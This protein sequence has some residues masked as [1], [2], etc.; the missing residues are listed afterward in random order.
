M[1]RLGHHLRI[2][3]M[4]FTRM[5]DG[6]KVSNKAVR[7][8]LASHREMITSPRVK[9]SLQKHLGLMYELLSSV[10]WYNTSLT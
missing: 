8:I 7:N 1:V 10:G 3:Y 2:L 4:L 5:P 9:L 6:D